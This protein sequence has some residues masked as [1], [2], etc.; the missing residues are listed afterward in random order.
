MLWM[1]SPSDEVN[2]K[3]CGSGASIS[4]IRAALNVVSGTW[5]SPVSLTISGG[6]IARS[7]IAASPPSTGVTVR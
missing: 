7:K 5:P 4:A 2:Q 1:R 6:W 3:C